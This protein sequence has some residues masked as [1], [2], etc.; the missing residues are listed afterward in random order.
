MKDL[1]IVANWKE[2]KTWEEA[3]DFLSEFSKIYEPKPNVKVAICPPYLLVPEVSNYVRTNNL[4]IDVGVQNLSKFD[5]GAHTGEVSAREAA[6]FARFAIIGHSERRA[7]GETD[8][9]VKMKVEMAIKYNIEP[10]VC[11]V[12]E[13]VPIPSGTKI[14]AYEP[15]EAIGTGNP[16]TP[17][18]ADRVA[19]AIKSK[20]QGIMHVLYGGSVTSENVRRF[21]QMQNID[22][23]LVGGASLDPK[24]FSAIVKQC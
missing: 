10:I 13:N 8:S 23:V 5:E 18:N 14:V 7:L 9:D 22:G 12:N 1:L 11:V 3:L 21:T 19:S 20:Y 6:E 15:I 17:E 24:E 2:N 4:S 16:D